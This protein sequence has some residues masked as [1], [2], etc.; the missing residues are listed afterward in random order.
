MRED[1]WPRL[2]NEVPAGFIFGGH[3][4]E[5]EHYYARR[6]LGRG[7]FLLTYTLEGE[8]YFRTT[9]GEKTCGAG[10]VGLLRADIPH[11][12]ATRPGMRWNFLWV[13]FP[14]VQE[15][16]YLPPDEVFVH[17]LSEG[18]MRDRVRHSFEHILLDSTGHTSF[19]QALCETSLKG[20][21]LLIASRLSKKRDPRI[22]QVL[23][24]MSQHIGKEIRIDTLAGIVGL[25]A[26]RLSH[27]FKEETGKSIVE[28][29]N[30]M[31]LRQ[32]A[33]LMEH[34]GRT[35]TEA[36]LDVGFNHYN[37]FA[38]MFKKAYGCSPRAYIR[39][40]RS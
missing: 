25:S 40:R 30:Q 27:L 20:I 34:M 26:S 1:R 4:D 18:A 3:M 39:Q 9:E 31:K 28:Q 6:P 23:A 33:L 2:E 8:G 29:L 32:A 38:E 14:K 15:I 13:H 36:S 11:E 7:D 35:A 37:H 12:Y 19:S 16:D 24:Y 5:D 17:T 21:L 22:E 10:Q